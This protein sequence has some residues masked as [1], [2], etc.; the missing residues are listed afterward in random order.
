[1]ELAALAMGLASA[2]YGAR[3]RSPFCGCAA[4]RGLPPPSPPRAARP[5]AR[6]VSPPWAAAA[7]PCAA[8]SRCGPLSLFGPEGRPAAQSRK[9]GWSRKL[10]TPIGVRWAES[11]PPPRGAVTQRSGVG[12][13]GRA[14]AA[15]SFRAGCSGLR[16]FAAIR[17]PGFVGGPLRAPAPRPAGASRGRPPAPLW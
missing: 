4:M 16:G 5:L 15:P 11:T 6:P 8:W 3:F 10:L 14:G 7:P 1:M 17:R 13:C 9:S 12:V 2:R